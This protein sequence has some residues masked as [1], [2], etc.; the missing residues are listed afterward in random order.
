MN[1]EKTISDVLHRKEAFLDCENI[2]FK[3]P[4]N[5]HFSKG[6]SPWFWSEISVF[7]TVSLY[8][9]Y[10]DNKY[11]LTFSLEN[12]PFYTK[13]TWIKKARLVYFI[14]GIVHDLGQKGALFSSFVFI[15]N[16]S[17]KRV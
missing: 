8:T 9:K 17:R 5:S 6:V 13:E 4:L 1:R 2:G 15:K 11:L 7:C 12:K 14:K 16:R 10:T 3:N